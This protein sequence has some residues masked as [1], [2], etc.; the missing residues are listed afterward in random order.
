MLRVRHEFF[1]LGGGDSSS[2]LAVGA[3]IGRRFLTSGW[4]TE[5]GHALCGSQ[6]CHLHQLLFR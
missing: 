4:A 1:G 5:G 6:R 3:G 2:L